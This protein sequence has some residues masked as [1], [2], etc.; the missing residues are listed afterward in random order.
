VNAFLNP[1]RL[2]LECYGKAHRAR[3]LF[4]FRTSGKCDG[5]ETLI[6]A[7]ESIAV[8]AKRRPEATT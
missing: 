3:T 5:C 4:I 6:A 1:D 7:V 8:V 2:C